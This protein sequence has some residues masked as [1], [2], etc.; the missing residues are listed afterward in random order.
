M[1]TTAIHAAALAVVISLAAVELF[2]VPGYAH[3]QTTG[4]ATGASSGF[5]GVVNKIVGIVNGGIIPL[6]YAIAFLVFVGGMARYFIFEGG[7]EGQEKGK[8]FA[9]HSIIGLVVIFSVWGIVNLLLNTLLSVTG[10]T[11]TG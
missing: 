2:G 1:K 10:G 8:K 3:A 6:M 11:G 5:A 9:L 4:A 7:A